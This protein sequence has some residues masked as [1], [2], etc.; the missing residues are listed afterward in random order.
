MP[1]QTDPIKRLEV[2]LHEVIANASIPAA[3]LK[4]A[5]LYALFPGGKRLRPRL[6]YLTGEL[7][8]VPYQALDSMAIAIEL[9]HAYSLVHDDLPAMD[10]DDMRRGKPS[11]HRAFDEATAI[12][13]GDGLQA[14]AVD[15]LLTQLPA[16]LP[17]PKVLL[18]THEL[19]KAS[20]PSGMVS[21]QSL[22]L[23]E[24]THQSVTEKALTEIHH[25]KTSKLM[26]ACINMVLAASNPS[27]EIT[28]ALRSFATH[29]GL[30]FQMQDDY[31]DAYGPTEGLGKNRAS[32]SAN[33]KSTFASCYTEKALQQMI[34]IHFEKTEE[35]LSVFGKQADP[36]RQL[37][38]ALLK[39]STALFVPQKL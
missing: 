21:G 27:P 9:M 1:S 12:L 29:L 10:D 2:C 11:C 20:G 17:A 34:Q 5:M 25:L 6:V 30:A 35:S 23:S 33:H 7:L 13:A 18:I 38:H 19:I 31:L 26:L 15:V 39:R 32:D 8:D 4:D 37:L 3:R 14:L 16:I 24:L 36:L 22:D 28:H